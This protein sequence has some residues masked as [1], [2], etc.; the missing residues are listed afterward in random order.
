QH[1]NLTHTHT[2]TLSLS[3]THTHT[4]THTHTLTHTHTQTLSH[5]H[6]HT[7]THTYIHTHTHTHTTAKVYLSSHPV[8]GFGRLLLKCNRLW[9]TS[10]LSS[11]SSVTYFYIT[12]DLFLI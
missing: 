2:H 5:T 6:T 9:I 1:G 12:F 10:Y 4:H 11:S 3:L 8:T 7:H